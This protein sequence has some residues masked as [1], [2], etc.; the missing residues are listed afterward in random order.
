MSVSRCALSSAVCALVLSGFAGVDAAWPLVAHSSADHAHA[1]AAPAAPLAAQEGAHAGHTLPNDTIP[2][3]CAAPT[4][5]S[6]GSGQWSDAAVWSPSRVPGAGDVVEISLGHTVTFGTIMTAAARCV[7]VNGRLQFDVTKS[8]KLWSGDIMVHTGGEMYVGDAAAPIPAN[9]TAEIVI[10]NQSLNLTTD[11]GQYGTALIV[12]GKLVMHGAVRDPTFVRVASELR[13]GDTTI[14]VTQPLTGWRVGDRI[15]IPDTRHL[16]Y[17]ETAGWAPVTPQWEERTIAAISLDGL[18]V[19]LASALTYAH[20]GARDVD[21]TLSFL[22]H[23]ANMSRNVVIRSETATGA[24]GTLGHTMMT[25]RSDADIRYVAFKDLGRT[26]TAPLHDTTN[27]IGR[28]SLHMHHLMGPVATPEN[29]YQ[30]TLMGNAIDGGNTPH[31]LKWG[32]AVHNTHYGLIKDNVLYNFDGAL[33]MFED[34]SESFN[35]VD[36]N[37]AVRSQGVGGGMAMATEGGGFWFRGANN[38]VRNN[39]TANLWASAPGASYGYK[40][41]LRYLGY[42]R[43]PIRKGADTSVT[44]EYVWRNANNMPILEFDNNEVYGAAHGLTYWWINNVDIA[45]QPNPAETVIRNLKIWHVFNMGVDHYPGTRIT[46]DGL[47]IRGRA[48]DGSQACCG[49]G[50]LAGDYPA[51]QVVI[52][53]SDIQGMTVG[54]SM[55][56]YATDVNTVENTHLSND[57]NIRVQ[58]LR[59]SSGA[60]NIPARTNIL[61]N[62]TFTSWPGVRNAGIYMDWNVVVGSNQFNPWQV[63]KTLVYQ[64]N[65]VVGDNFQTYY[66]QQATQPFAG[67]LAPCTSSH[68]GVAGLACRL[69]LPFTDSTLAGAPIRVIHISELRTRINTARSQAALAAFPWTDPTLTAGVTPIRAV[70]IT[71]LRTAL[72]QVYAARGQNP[73]NYTDPVLGSLVR[74]KAVHVTELRAGVLALE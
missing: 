52:R 69:S 68:S 55:S 7:G 57:I 10:A 66:Y 13:A 34:G 50:W 6:V 49:M 62:L 1:A 3:F 53:N 26:T 22:P 71:E 42:I 11:P 43:V 23:I 30:F 41:F 73:P 27:H 54:I 20:L 59:S 32:L 39:V 28:Y 72:T 47:T 19:T 51:G 4:I 60:Q 17:V 5:R 31:E 18:S 70:H 38:Y 61:R 24:P 9:L 58:S 21:G 65:G 2:D 63:D 29:G 56:S 33:V 67:G 12:M 64:F 8:T 16:R 15:V 74:M 48:P 37:F 14:A 35:V 25:H 36:H 44:G 40:F 46:F 45:P